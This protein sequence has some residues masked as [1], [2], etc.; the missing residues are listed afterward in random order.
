MDVMYATMTS[1]GQITLPVAA[2]RALGLHKGHRVEIRIEG[3]SLVIDAPRDLRSVRARIREEAEQR[4][5]WDRIPVSGDGWA[6][7]G[8]EL[9]GEGPRADD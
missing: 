8:E 1:K 6:A 9:A 5:T 4:G 3:D 2:R 7:R